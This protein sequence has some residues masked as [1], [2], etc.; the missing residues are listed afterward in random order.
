MYTKK[1]WAQGDTVTE[2][3]INN[4]E[5]G[6]PSLPTPELGKRLQVLLDDNT[7]EDLVLIPETSITI[8]NGEEADISDLLD[9]MLFGN[10]LV[11]EYQNNLTFTVGNESGTPE[12]VGSNRVDLEGSQYDYTVGLSYGGGATRGTPTPS[13]PNG[14]Y[15]G[16]YDSNG[17]VV[18]GTYTIS[19][20]ISLPKAYWGLE[21]SGIIS[22]ATPISDQPIEAR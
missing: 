11:S 1:V 13:I 21:V 12:V 7:M 22:D 8:S 18:N 19:L 15:F 17:D 2:T 4:I 14:A 9:Y 20:S 6:I 16:A 10:L 5:N 3:A